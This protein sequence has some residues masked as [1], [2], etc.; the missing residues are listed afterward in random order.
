M[1]KDYFDDFSF[2]MN[3]L[4]KRFMFEYKGVKFVSNKEIVGVNPKTFELIYKN[5]N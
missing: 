2:V 4:K 5:K 1:E 3:N